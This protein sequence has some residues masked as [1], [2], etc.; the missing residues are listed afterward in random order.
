M[1]ASVPVSL[2]G[3]LSLL[4]CVVLV[5]PADRVP[6]AE[7]AIELMP[8]IDYFGRDYST[9]KSVT[10][11]DCQ[12]ACLNDSRCRAFTYNTKAE[13]CFLKENHEEARPFA[14][15]VSGHV[16]ERAGQVAGT[17]GKAQR[18]VSSGAR[19]ADLG[20]LPPR[21]LGE[22]RRLAAK[23]ASA[24]VPEVKLAT[25]TAQ[26]RTALQSEQPAQAAAL[27]SQALRLTPDDL[28]LWTSLAESSLAAA[29]SG[30]WDER[31]RHRRQATAA[32]INAHTH[33]QND[34]ERAAT[35]AL[36]ARTLAQRNEW[37]AAIKANRAALALVESPE[38][39]RIL[40]QQVAEHGFRVSGHEVDSDAAGPRICIQFT[41]PLDLRRP[42]LTDFVRVVARTDLPIEAE[43]KQ[44][45]IDGVRHGERY[46]VLVRPGLPAADGETLSKGSELDI[47]VRDRAPMARFLGR[48]YVLP[49]GGEAAIPVVSV[50]TDTLEAEVHRLGDRVLTQALEEG[51]LE[52]Q[53]GRWNLERIRERTGESIWKGTIEVKPELNR[54]V[55]TA[56]PVGALVSELKPGIHVL[57]VRPRNAPDDGSSLATQWFLVSD[58]GLTTLAGNDGLHALVRSL[59]SAKP[60]GRVE[61]RLVAVNN[62]IL[63]RATTDNEGH[64]RFD[65]GLLRGTG[66]NAPALLA[67]ESSAGD[68]AFLD[69]TQSPFDLSDRGVDGRLP[70]KPLDVYLVSER[71]AY[72]PGE[73]VH[74]TALVRDSRARA[75]TDLPITLVVKRPDGMEY[76]RT[77]TQD[78]GQGGHAADV[79]LTRT[80][81]RGTWRAAVHADPKGPALAELAFLVEDFLPERLTFELD[82]SSPAIDPAD[83][84][85][86]RLDARFLYGA[87]AGGL[88]LEGEIQVK[89]TETLAAFPGYRF[90]LASEELEPL[91]VPLSGGRTDAAGHAEV[92]LDLPEIPPTTKLLEAEIQV[93][94]LE[95]GGRPVERQLKRPVASKQTRIGLKPLF[96]DSVEEG[97]NARF[98]AIAI[99]ADGQRQSLT[100]VRWTL[101]RLKTSFQW[102]ASDGN[103]NYEP[104]TT[105][106]RVADGTL[107]LGALDAGRIEAAVDWG[108]YR[109]T[110]STSDSAVLPVDLEFE[111]GWYVQPKTQDTPDLLKVSLDK[112]SYRVGDKARVRLEPRFAGLA[113]VMVVDDRL[114]SM[115]AVEVPEDGATVELPVTAE[116]GPGAYVTAAL[117][118]PM[119]LEARRMPGRALG[120]TW[121]GVDPGARKLALTLPETPQLSG[122][123]RPRQTLEIPVRVEGARSGQP[124]YVTVSAVDLG[125][126]NL[127]R[128]QPPAPDDW[129]FAQ[130]R[131]GMEIRDLYGRLID[132]MQGVPGVVRTGGDGLGLS[133]EGPP[134][135]EE[136]LAYHSGIV[137]LDDRGQAGVSVEIPDFNGTVRVMAMAWSAEGV[138][139]AVRDLTVRDPIVVTPTLPRFLAPGDRSRLLLGLDAVEGPGGEVG[140][141]VVAEGDQIQVAPE[142][143]RS[144]LTLAEGERGQT[145]VAFQ[146]E[147]VGDARLNIDLLT[148]DGRTLRKT[149]R[150]PV[151]SNAPRTSRTEVVTLQPGEELTLDAG[152]LADRVTGTGSLLVSIGGAGRLDV[153]GLLMALDRYP[154]GCVEQLTSRALPLLYLND[155]AQT[156]G[157]AGEGGASE[158]VRT[159]IGEILAK[160]DGSGSFGIW[161][162]DGGGDTWLD[163]YVTDFLTRAREKGYEV[164]DAPF[165]MALD[166]LRNSL[167]YAPDF[168]SGGE[169][170]AYALYVL[171]RNGR[172]AI[173][174]LRYYADTKLD[175]FATPLAV[176]QL[177]AALAIQGD[178][179]RADGL[180]RSALGKLAQS[181]DDRRWRSDYGSL[182]R[183]GAGLLTLAA[184]SESSAVNLQSLAQ[185]LQALWV[186][187][188]H[189]STQ[190]Q[191]WLL[192][193]AHALM[194]SSEQPALSVD[195]AAHAGVFHRRVDD[196]QLALRPLSI[197]NRGT[198][199]VEALVTMTGVP[200]VPEP[201]DG[202]GYRI[203]RAYYDLEG[204]RVR[205]AEVEQG[206]RLIAVLTVEAT[207]PRQARLILDDPLPAGLEIDNPNLIR[208]GDVSGIPWLGLENEA[209]HT[210]FRADRFIAA[211]DRDADDSAQFQLA[212]RLRAVSPGVFAHPAATVE[213]MYRPSL[214]AWTETGTV[215]VREP[216]Q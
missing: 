87:P 163:A 86:L 91:G 36:I 153:A 88:T 180:F 75:V 21:E 34:A 159:A 97:G 114:I 117:Y 214:R 44:I 120:L 54:E 82:S 177:A 182:L 175:A 183:D 154:Y 174:D 63:G 50:N 176:S 164:P 207:E 74:L 157:L 156:A 85:S 60:L 135:T 105:T 58:L 3:R 61:V 136:L 129:Y 187:E 112:P 46:Q 26:A 144:S 14:G 80:A 99:G 146:A 192:L 113:L 76:L 65:P 24:P 185:R 28:G 106:E 23:L 199:P 22:A 208:A 66:G 77:L 173:G 25:L 13:W 81:P 145:G 20:F 57:T 33:A 103:W 37:R 197:V 211:I 132:R 73:T 188:S 67:A 104:I 90:G 124:V 190:E 168:S 41:D 71:G 19:L 126:L 202:Q 155:V 83:P 134:P 161:G 49:K 72:R 165:Q 184:E 193:A 200:R 127:T 170:I 70:P 147:S 201:A 138:G 115:K 178:R 43:S 171:A 194:Q 12:T 116:W 212:Y 59:S 101:A 94:V 47:Y 141:S 93:R 42:N 110:L 142:S 56:V 181:H 84:P 118:R 213:D 121:A 162:N 149:L 111:A 64:A 18:P 139:H 108:R 143:A 158:R 98:E 125:I 215:E 10:L 131:L 189:T 5:W 150:V 53:L 210:E 15:A 2:L 9:L 51:L 27:Q 203:E 45:C 7:R 78:Q 38:L 1:S 11:E 55:T 152:R 6:A 29:Q 79:Q 148:P 119:D 31:Q 169:D 186:G 151:R 52:Q 107:D 179:P 17:D 195:G 160:Q 35:L 198:S 172:A 30:D 40:D 216:E 109:L 130:R 100:G 4:L 133:I 167:S 191:A 95:E 137:K 8:G 39:R 48:A 123:V 204:R 96:E 16:V 206:Q 32:A 196:A 205:L 209:R 69:L 166:N 102:Y 128:Y 92:T 68:Y 140:L 62:E 122:T 89:P